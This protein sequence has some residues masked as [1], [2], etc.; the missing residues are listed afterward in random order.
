MEDVKVWKEVQ[1]QQQLSTNEVPGSHHKP[2][3]TDI[4][5]GRPCC[6]YDY[7]CLLV[8]LRHVC[9]SGNGF[10][11]MHQWTEGKGGKWEVVQ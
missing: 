1:Q 10:A 7:V 9:M 4:A 3:L 2:L 5:R 6:V 8:D 11:C